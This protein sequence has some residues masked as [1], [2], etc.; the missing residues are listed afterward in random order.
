[1]YICFFNSAIIYYS[2]WC[3]I[4]LAN[5]EKSIYL[6]YIIIMVI[7]IVMRY[8]L[9]LEKGELGDPIDVIYRCI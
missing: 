7:F 3:T 9:D 2:L 8:S 1:M 5:L 6:L 4:G